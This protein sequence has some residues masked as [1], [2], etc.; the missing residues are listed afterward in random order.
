MRMAPVKPSTFRK[1]RA[2]CHQGNQNKSLRYRS[3]LM[4]KST[5]SGSESK[6]LFGYRT[7]PLQLLPRTSAIVALTFKLRPDPEALGRAKDSLA[8]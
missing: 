2:C 5:Q 8:R 3:L 6:R 1:V 4:P 7:S